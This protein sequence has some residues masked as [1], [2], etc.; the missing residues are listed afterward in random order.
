MKIKHLIKNSL[1]SLSLIFILLIIFIPNCK[2]W[3][4]SKIQSDFFR[5]YYQ[6]Y[7]FK[8]NRI[9]NCQ[10]K[11]TNKIQQNSLL[12]IGHHYGNPN[13]NYTSY[14]TNIDT[15]LMKL[16]KKNQKKI[17]IVIFT[18]DIFNI[19]SEKKWLNLINFFEDIN[20]DFLIAP[21]NHDISIKKD[22]DQK[23]F[24]D[25]FNYE[26]PIIFTFKNKIIYVR[27]TINMGWSLKNDE[28]KLIN[29]ISQKKDIY[30]IQ[31]HSALH[32]F[33]FLTHSSKE[34]KFNQSISK[35]KKIYQEID[36][37]TKLNF[38]IGDSGMYRSQKR[39]N[40]KMSN[41]IRYI[42]NGLGG[43]QKDKIIVLANDELFYFNL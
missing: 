30:I 12:I 42:V 41:N 6:S 11:E 32:E 8:V 29:N 39:I 34:L 20:L 24:N 17:D 38:I 16:I 3:R 26:Y 19:P 25:L 23:I 10:L 4:C 13:N 14:D 7:L 22:F 40:C 43:Y 15:R 31:H 2:H 27:D 33:R 35:V 37:N 1:L 28:I 18:G 9:K 21:G 5:V 36:K